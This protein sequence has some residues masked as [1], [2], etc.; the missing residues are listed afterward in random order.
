MTDLIQMLRDAPGGS[1]ELDED[2][3]CLLQGLLYKGAITWSMVPHYTT[4]IDA[5]LTL[6]PEGFNLAQCGSPLYDK[7]YWSATL[8]RKEDAII[9]HGADHAPTPALAI[10]IASY[11]AHQYIEGRTT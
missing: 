4:S 1:R 6:V 9:K 5:A 7:E 8:K 2:I 11:K 3:Y 10:C